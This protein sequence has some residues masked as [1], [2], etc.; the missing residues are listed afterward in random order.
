MAKMST[1]M[2]ELYLAVVTIIDVGHVEWQIF[3]RMS[4]RPMAS[5]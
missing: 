4:G 5:H 1:F 2:S 3:S